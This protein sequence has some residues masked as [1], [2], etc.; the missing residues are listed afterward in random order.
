MANKLLFKAAPPGRQVPFTDAVNHESAP[1]YSM[2]P[3]QTLAQ[4]A[5]TGCLNQ[6]FYVSGEE[7]LAVALDA[8]AKCSPMFVAKTAVWARERAF[9]KDMPALLVAHIA[10]RT[11]AADVLPRALRV[12]DNG[13]ML[14]NVVQILRSGQLGRKSIPRPVRRFI[15]KALVTA[16]PETLL[17]WSVGDK[18]SLGDIIAMVHPKPDTQE[19]AYLLGWLRANTK[20]PAVPREVLPQV[21]RQYLDFCD[22][23]KPDVE[24]PDVPWEMLTRLP[25]TEDGWVRLAKSMRWHALRMNLNT[26][27]RHAVFTDA[28]MVADVAARLRDAETIR[29]SRVFPYQ[30]LAAYLN[31]D[32]VPV[33]I[34]EALQDA[35]EVATEAVPTLPP[36][37]LCVDVS[38]SMQ[39]AITGSRHGA[40]SK[41][42]CVD[43]AGL[44]AS[45][46][47]RKSPESAVFPF[48]TTLHEAGI[49]PRDTVMTNAQTLA[50]LGRGGTACSVPL[51]RL[52]EVAASYPLVIY[53]SDNESW[54]DGDATGPMGA[55]V[56]QAMAYFKMYGAQ[57]SGNFNPAQWQNYQGAM[58][59]EW[60]QYEQRVRGAKLVLIDLTPNATSQAVE[61]PN[62]LR[63]GGFSDA[64]FGLVADFVAGRMSAD[65]W[66][67]KINEVEL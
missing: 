9:M 60:R 22:P 7:Q 40:T 8:A 31:T 38:G 41:V 46:L 29:K 15:R 17:R 66:V 32:G 61:E 2:T 33:K 63:V 3:E 64:V 49:N 51:A 43:V 16:S 56:A 47:L 57:W 20:Q 37:A 67:G 21:V 1:A 4:L 24:A 12:I 25:L 44:I 23:E 18:P 53:V 30:L 54:A 62:I 45:C 59:R 42:R 65:H 19:R 26:L 36:T 39:S 48:D 13:K 34:R 27:Q 50:A 5:S 58:M 11:D 14:R 55:S 52:N 10:C 6:T 35:L 28:A